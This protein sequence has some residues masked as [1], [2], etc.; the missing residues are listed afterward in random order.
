MPASCDKLVDMARG[1]ESK[2]VESQIEEAE[3][4]FTHRETP[5]L[6]A[7]ELLV[8]RERESIELSR[9]RILSDIE[10]AKNPKYI[11]VLQRSLRFLDEKLAA[12]ESLNKSNLRG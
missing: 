3:A 5:P 8:V 2:E 4:R 11:E 10:G 7:S 12:F 9:S 1:W 6:S